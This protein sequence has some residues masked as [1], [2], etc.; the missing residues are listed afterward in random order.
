MSRLCFDDVGADAHIGPHLFVGTTR[1]SGG[2][3][4]ERSLARTFKGNA[5]TRAFP[6][7]MYR[8]TKNPFV[9]FPRRPIPTSCHSE[10]NEESPRRSQSTRS[11]LRVEEE[12][13]GNDTEFFVPQNENAVSVLCSDDLSLSKNLPRRPPL[14]H[15]FI[16]L[17]SFSV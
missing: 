10:C 17:P 3:L 5:R 12:E 15:A 11:L 14:L 4:L 1:A 6:F 13:Q 2:K 7:G 8:E 16:S 9:S